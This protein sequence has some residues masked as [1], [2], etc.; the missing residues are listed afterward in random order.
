MREATVIRRACHAAAVLAVALLI[1][2]AGAFAEDVQT[3]LPTLEGRYFAEG[4]ST[5]SLLIVPLARG[6]CPMYRI[7]TVQWE[8][9]GL[10]DGT[11]YW[12]VFHRGQRT[13][14]PELA[15]ASGTHRA[16]LRPDGSLAVHG[17]YTA[18]RTGSFE[19]MWRPERDGT[20]NG[21]PQLDEYVYVE[22]LPEA[23]TKWPPVYPQAAREAK[24]EGTVMVQALVG[25]D[26]RVK[27]TRVLHSVAGLD[28]AAVESV[29]QWVFK[30]A[31]TAGKPVAVW[32]AVPVKFSL[33]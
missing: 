32:V 27:Q 15:G 17:E 21:L 30:P 3:A 2:S 6:E 12:G 9:V 7:E 31:R 4:D 10:F 23:V 19:T 24:V 26:G 8:G 14:P 29:L 25:R 22:E 11:T 28:D 18:G 16:T 1:P 13:S 20:P 5:G 33:R